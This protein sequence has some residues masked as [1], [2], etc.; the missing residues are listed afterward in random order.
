MREFTEISEIGAAVGEQLG[1][2]EWYPIDQDRVNAFG[3]VTEDPQWIHTDPRRAADGPFGAPIAH[4]YLLLSLIPRLLGEIYRVRRLGLMINLGVDEL[5][6]HSAVPVGA[7][8]RAAATIVAATPRARSALE[9][10]LQVTME[11]RDREVRRTACTGRLRFL[12]RP[13]SRLLLDGD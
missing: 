8:V 1:T 9:L 7:A 10:D 6:F 11:C 5:L 3:S 4:G 2:S 12:V 13:P